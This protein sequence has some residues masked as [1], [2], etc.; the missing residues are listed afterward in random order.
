MTID[1]L[2]GARIRRPDPS[3]NLDPETLAFERFLRAR[4]RHDEPDR[5]LDAQVRPVSEEWRL[6][7]RRPAYR[8]AVAN[9]AYIWRDAGAADRFG[10]MPAAFAERR[11]EVQGAGLLLPASAPIWATGDY[12]IWEEADQATAALGDPTA[13]A[14]WHVMLEIPVTIPRARWT[15]LVTG[16]AERELTAKGAV[17]AWAVH[18][19]A[20]PDGE[21]IVRP[22][23]HM[24]V[25]A[26]HWRHDLRHRR[27]HPGW[28]GRTR[29][30]WQLASKWR[31][32]MSRACLL[33]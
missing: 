24:V 7:G 22:H 4:P 29:H 30:Q 23:C 12:T 17:T 11:C 32:E 15:T 31:G 9:V 16:F 14:A 13:V 2:T 19:L 1:L 8:T 33:A 21:W 25:T 10:P 20:G 27:R 28:I 18:A 3:A 6:L 5:Q 26:L